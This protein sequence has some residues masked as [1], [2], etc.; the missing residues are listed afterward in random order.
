M[1]VSGAAGD[2]AGP[3]AGGEGGGRVGGV[4]V[5]VAIEGRPERQAGLIDSA[6]QIEKFTRK[7]GKKKEAPAPAKA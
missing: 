1:H 5:A 7:W 2:R 6:G 3:E 4:D